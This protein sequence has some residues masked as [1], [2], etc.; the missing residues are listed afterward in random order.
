[1]KM[2]MGRKIRWLLLGVSGLLLTAC[3]TLPSSGSAWLAAEQRHHPLVGRFWSVQEQQFVDFQVWL[4]ALPGDQWVLV[5]EQHD[6]PDHQRLPREWLQQLAESDRLG[7]LALEM[8][9]QPQQPALDAALR[10]SWVTPERLEWQQG[11]PWTRYGELVQAGLQQASRVLA[12]DLG[13]EAQRQA[14]QQGAPLVAVS[15]SQAAVLDRLIDE[16][17]CGLL[18]NEHL[19]SMRQVQLARDQAMAGILAS[20]PLAGRIGLVQVGSV[21]ARPDVGIPRWLPEALDY[22]SIWLRQVEADRQ[23]PEAYLFEGAD[24]LP[25]ADYIYFTPAIAPV[26]YC[27]AFQSSSRR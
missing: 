8:A 14:Y 18:P 25:V 23:T 27:A 21:H 7:P 19:P 5:G 11:W 2:G 13:R 22:T 20:E 10:Q 4:A 26:D 24:G 1:M 6:H 16:G 12:A 9:R 15:E 17:H 3:Q